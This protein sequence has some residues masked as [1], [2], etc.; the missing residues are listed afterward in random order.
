MDAYTSD[1]RGKR[2]ARVIDTRKVV[3]LGG[4]Q[5]I[6][7][8]DPGCAPATKPK[9]QMDRRPGLNFVVPECSAVFE[10]LSRED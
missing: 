7:I 8:E 10:L 2:D 5:K 6:C 1:R 4:I 3:I 9:N